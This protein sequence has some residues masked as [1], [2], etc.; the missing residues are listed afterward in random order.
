MGKTKPERSPRKCCKS[1][2][3]HGKKLDG[4]FFLRA[5]DKAIILRNR[6]TRCSFLIF[7]LAQETEKQNNLWILWNKANPDGVCHVHSE[8]DLW[9]NHFF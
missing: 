2:Q 4:A 3:T 8:S 6:I 7:V 5:R 9:T 1:Y